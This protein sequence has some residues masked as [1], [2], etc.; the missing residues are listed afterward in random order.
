[1]APRTFRERVDLRL[2]GCV[3]LSVLVGTFLRVWRA[4]SPLLFQDELFAVAAA[5]DLRYT[6]ILT[7]FGFFDHCIPLSL[8]AK[9][10]TA[11]VGL[12]EWTLRLPGIG[13][14]IAALSL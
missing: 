4:G 14:G 13:A 10:L 7:H 5:A 3:L 1:M 2:L 12:D 8:Y 6:Y 9:L 11:T